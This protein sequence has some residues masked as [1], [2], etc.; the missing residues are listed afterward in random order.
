MKTR[1]NALLGYLQAVAVPPGLSLFSHSITILEGEV[2]MAYLGFRVWLNRGNN[3]NGESD[4]RGRQFGLIGTLSW[5]LRPS[6]DCGRRGT[7][8]GARYLP[9]NKSVPSSGG[10][11]RILRSP[12]NPAPPVRVDS[13]SLA[14]KIGSAL[15]FIRQSFPYFPTPRSM[16]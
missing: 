9:L 12:I 8:E 1:L 7:G 2:E 3:V 5:Q 6:R 4:R 15:Q 11:D 14:G 16:P 10:R 13:R